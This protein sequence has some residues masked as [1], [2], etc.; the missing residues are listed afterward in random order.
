[1]PSRF[2][3]GAYDPELVKIMSQALDRAWGDFEPRPK[4]QDLAR[5]LMASAI[6]E[7]IE[8]GEHEEDALLRKATVTLMKAI[9]VD[10]DLLNARAPSAGEAD[11]SDS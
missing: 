7:A 2:T 5:S 11:S 10:P 3:S 9:K 1:M 8:A 4:N 6:I